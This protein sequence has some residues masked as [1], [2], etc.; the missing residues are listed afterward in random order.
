V[1]VGRGGNLERDAATVDR[2][3]EAEEGAA[4]V[5]CGG[6]LVISPSG[7]GCVKTRRNPSVIA[8]RWSTSARRACHS[9]MRACM[10]PPASE[11]AIGGEAVAPPAVSVTASAAAPVQHPQ[12][13]ATAESAPASASASASMVAVQPQLS[14]HGP[15]TGRPT[16]LAAVACSWAANATCSAMWRWISA[17][18]VFTTDRS[19]CFTGPHS[20]ASHASTNPAI[21]SSV[22]PSSLARAMSRSRSA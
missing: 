10:S 13:P 7:S 17:T 2:D 15:S 9:P 5:L 12:P 20:S 19:R 14:S 1:T 16:R 6:N 11:Q 3:G 21:S 8:S 18:F 4:V 22:Q